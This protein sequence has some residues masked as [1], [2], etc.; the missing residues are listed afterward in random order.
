MIDRLTN[1]LSTKKK[2]KKSKKTGYIEFWRPLTPISCITGDDEERKKE[3]LKSNL[4][5]STTFLSPSLSTSSSV[6]SSKHSLRRRDS[7]SSE[8]ICKKLKT[9]SVKLVNEDSC[10]SICSSQ[11][12]L[13][14]SSDTSVDYVDKK[15][16]KKEA[17]QKQSN[18]LKNKQFK[19][20]NLKSSKYL[21]SNLN[22]TNRNQFEQSNLNEI[23]VK[24][25]EEQFD[26]DCKENNSVETMTRTQILLDEF[27]FT[28][29]RQLR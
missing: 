13:N 11:N 16:P 12:S 4:E 17:K 3:L 8:S 6:H 24:L 2:N 15:K 9:N 5:N 29:G 18:R 10:S 20:K 28:A 1:N 23:K 25:N 7:S 14:I 26:K 21:S 19:S 27:C 22:E